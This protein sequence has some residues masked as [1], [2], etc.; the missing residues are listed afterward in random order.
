MRRSTGLGVT[1]FVG[2]VLVIAA[3]PS[4]PVVA[5]GDDGVVV[6][7]PGV[8]FHKAGSSDIRGKGH[9][10][11]LS[12][13]L[14]AGYS[15]CKDCFGREV[16]VNMRGAGAAGAA[17]TSSVMGGQLFSLAGKSS[18]TIS[19][20]FGLKAQP[21]RGGKGAARSIRNPYCGQRTIQFPGYEQGAYGG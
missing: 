20:P 2:L 9:G 14:A 17:A 3:F 18:S 19:Q 10:K 1:L 4:A 15:P 12:D 5:D 7:R 6:S 11:S 8:V 21:R 16:S 13:A